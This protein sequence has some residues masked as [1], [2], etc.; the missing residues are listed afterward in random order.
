MEKALYQR[1]YL[2][3]QILYVVGTSLTLGGDDLAV[4]NALISQA[5]D[6][7]TIVDST[8]VSADANGKDLI[9]CSASC[10]TVSLG[11]KFRDSVVPLIMCQVASGPNY[12]FCGATANSAINQQNWVRI[13]GPDPITMNLADGS[14]PVLL[15]SQP[16]TYCT[17]I[18]A[19]AKKLAY[20]SGNSA[21]NSIF[22][23][24][25]GVTMDGVFVA[26]ERRL[27][28]GNNNMSHGNPAECAQLFYDYAIQCCKWAM[29]LGAYGWGV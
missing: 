15:A 11:T 26:P 7:E 24:E 6:V 22:F 28:L 23:F 5:W 8:A 20:W 9:F 4:Y 14:S 1:G 21:R 13:N 27:M 19:T 16:H 29:R 12:E 10:D 18:P 17:S 25:K 2:K 3:P